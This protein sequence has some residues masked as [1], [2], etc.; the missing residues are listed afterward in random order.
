MLGL[1]VVLL[2]WVVKD[3][4]RITKQFAGADL[5]N[6]IVGARL[7][8]RGESPYFFKWQAA[9]PE[10]LLDPYD[11]PQLFVS[12][13]TASPGMLYMLVPLGGMSYVHVRYVWWVL[14]YVLVGLL[15]WAMWRWAV[16]YEDSW[17][18]GVVGVLL[19]MTF[20]AAWKMNIDRGQNALLYIPFLL[21]AAGLLQ[22]PLKRYGQVLAGVVLAMLVWTRPT[23]LVLALPVLCAR[24]WG[25]AL[26]AGVG[27]VLLGSITLLSAKHTGY[28][29]DFVRAAEHWAYD[30]TTGM[31][32]QNEQLPT[33]PHTAEGLSN[34]DMATYVIQRCSLQRYAKE[35]WQMNLQSKQLI[36]ILMVIYGVLVLYFWRVWMR[37]SPRMLLMAFFV[38]YIITDYLLP[39]P[40]YHYNA[41]LWLL[42]IGIVGMQYKQW[43]AYTTAAFFVGGALF[44]VRPALINYSVAIGEI[45]ML[46]GL[47]HHIRYQAGNSAIL[48]S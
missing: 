6:R 13:V 23:F 36:T 43:S 17:V 48:G 22:T 16:P 31:P 34:Y 45:F 26:G 12:R 7:I 3:D 40:R 2:Y 18:G 28:W 10:V 15:L 35:N 32:H 33:L 14:Q 27:L 1:L 41:V 19:F 8:E 38:F 30:Q 25:M 37:M 24:K 11:D 20:A 9:H 4:L 5:R 39:M 44:C 29:K 21:A 47:I 46:L 42:P